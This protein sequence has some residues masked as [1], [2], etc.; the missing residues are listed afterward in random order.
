MQVARKDNPF[1]LFAGNLVSLMNSM[2]PSKSQADNSNDAHSLEGTDTVVEAI[3]RPDDDSH[4]NTSAGPGTL[5]ATTQ[6]L[7]HSEGS[8]KPPFLKRIWQKFNIY[9]LLFILVILITIT[10]TIILFLKDRQ[11]AKTAEGVI[12][13]QNLSEEALKQLANSNVSVGNSKQLL[14]VESNAIFAGSVLVRNNIEVAGSI[15]V[16]GELQLPGI[17]VSGS[18][19][20]SNLQA[21][22]L[23]IGSSATV[24][25]VLNARSGIN[26]SGKS[27]FAGPLSADSISAN[28][29]QLNGDL[30][31][32]NHITAGGPVP[33]I[34]RGNALGSG[35]TVS[36]SGSD[37]TG[38]IVINT[39]SG[40]GAGC[41]ATITFV[42]RFNG[43]PHVAVTPIG[44]GA[45]T[46][47]YYVNRSTSEFSICTTNPAPAGQTFGFDYIILN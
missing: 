39:G 40:P 25:G 43:A 27:T 9:L 4:D 10:V 44:S 2:D 33:S 11:A 42:K 24:Q 31:L 21:D 14:T 38:S 15:K 32:T 46:L 29:L 18:S 28:S 26:V 16:G 7:N 6:N 35:G 13:S 37:S 8:H 17:T 5:D 1:T 22:N 34:A 47:E 30:V 3:S 45:A 19:R 23:A 12:T 41:F 20:F 36:L